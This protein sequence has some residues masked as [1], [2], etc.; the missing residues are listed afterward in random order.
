MAEE[1]Q[2]EGV[3]RSFDSLSRR[4]SAR[5]LGHK[6]HLLARLFRAGLP[7]PESWVLEARHFDEHAKASLPR[8]HDVKS[9]IKAA[10]TSVGDER[11]ARA[12]QMIR[13]SGLASPVE[14]AAR[15]LWQAK[16]VDWRDGVVIRPSLAVSSGAAEPAGIHL[17]TRAGIDDEHAFL[18]ALREVW[19]SGVL[20]WTVGSYAA[21]SV[22]DASV[23]LVVQP[24]IRTRARGL[25]TY[26]RDRSG[27]LSWHIGVTWGRGERSRPQWR[28]RAQW[29]LTLDEARFADAPPPPLV[30]IREALGPEGFVRLL[31]LGERARTEIGPD[32]VLYFGI[33]EEKGEPVVL[34]VEESPRWRA[35]AGGEASTTWLEVTLGPTTPEPPTRLSQSVVSQ[36]ANAALSAT[37]ADY[38]VELE[39]GAELLSSFSGRTYLNVDR[40]VAPLRNL[41]FIEVGDALGALGGLGQELTGALITKA[42]G[43]GPQWL[44]LPSRLSATVR[45]QMTL[46]ADLAAAERQLERE[47]GNFGDFDLSIV[48]GDAIDVTLASAQRML[49][50]AATLWLEACVGELG[51]HA[52]IRTMLERRIAEVHGSVGYTMTAGF[53][54]GIGVSFAEQFTRLVADLERDPTAVAA[55]RKQTIRR[56]AD[57]PDGVARG[58]LGQVLARYGHLS[59]DPFELSRP[60]FRED[61]SDLVGLV[62]QVVG[63]S[64]L[65][66]PT[67]QRRKAR[68]QADAQLARFEPELPPWERRGLRL[69]VD[70]GRDLARRRA[71]L[72]RSIFHALY[73]VRRVA[74]DIER[75][76]RRMDGG[77]VE[78][79]PFH[80]SANR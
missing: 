44:R 5:R 74:L 69:L 42:A 41:P 23:A 79:A 50:R 65:L 33:T 20:G 13:E 80:C 25:L 62:L 18:G 34:N 6:A 55:M 57:L 32:V 15:F 26:L 72:D 27:G 67:E 11:C 16:R 9:L 40:V 77:M 10:G 3:F 36:M 2:R 54:D 4:D 60:R 43:R 68:A 45:A 53:G 61:A 28:R 70:R 29:L 8:R 19:S 76:L 47:L 1:N 35:L 52:A 39:S 73:A 21:A 78:R 24:R 51:V 37:L 48:P 58:A 22:K 17:L 59:L 63:V 7:L 31:E 75:R 38:D 66:D 49:D 12:F 46:D 14:E 56:A 30:R 71:G 64:D